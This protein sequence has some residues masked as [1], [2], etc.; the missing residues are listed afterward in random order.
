MKHT[1]NSAL[2]PDELS[3]IEYEEKPRRTHFLNGPKNYCAAD[4]M[5]FRTSSMGFFLFKDK[6][7]IISSEEIQWLGG[8]TSGKSVIP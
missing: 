5:L 7:I 1:L 6:L 4:Q 8:K 2:D 3:R